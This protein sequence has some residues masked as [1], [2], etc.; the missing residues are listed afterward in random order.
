M[1]DAFEWLWRKKFDQSLGVSC[2][3]KQV[4][5]A[6][7]AAARNTGGG[8]GSLNCA[9]SLKLSFGASGVNMSL[10]QLLISH[11]SCSC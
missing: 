1:P 11:P 5:L 9:S 10:C 3:V 6:S 4:V 2:V 8:G 7:L